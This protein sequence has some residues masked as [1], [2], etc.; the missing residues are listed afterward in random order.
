[1]KH[2]QNLVKVQHRFDPYITSG[3]SEAN[4]YQSIKDINK[5]LKS[6][7]PVFNKSNKEL[8]LN[9]LLNDVYKFILK[10]EGKLPSKCYFYID[11]NVEPPVSINIKN[12][13]WHKSV[14]FYKNMLELRKR[15]INIIGTFPSRVEWAFW[16]PQLVEQETII[17]IYYCC[18]Q[19]TIKIKDIG[20]YQW[21]SDERETLNLEELLRKVNEFKTSVSQ[22]RK[23]ADIRFRSVIKKTRKLLPND[24]KIKTPDGSSDFLYFEKGKTNPKQINRVYFDY[25]WS[26]NDEKTI[27]VK[28]IHKPHINNEL[29]K[30]TF[31]VNDKNIVQD[32]LTFVTEKMKLNKKQ[33][34]D[35]CSF[36]KEVVHNAKNRK[37]ELKCKKGKADKWATAYL[38]WEGRSYDGPV[39]RDINLCLDRII[40]HAT[41]PIQWLSWDVGIIFAAPSPIDV[42]Y[43]VRSGQVNKVDK[44]LDKE[45]RETL[46]KNVGK[47]VTT[48]E[49]AEEDITEM[50]QY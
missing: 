1:M 32:V 38:D 5:L 26:Y 33:F 47:V 35:E 8:D 3:E 7:I 23:N 30:K 45:L 11:P 4:D 49:E 21:Q 14:N 12:R 17:R 34:D 42:N 10:R 37:I 28:L 50:C 40:K 2:P 41:G 18:N 31:N 24:I 15:I 44:E 20:T 48:R 46:N 25:I 13:V 43:M 16:A 19:I 9:I 6:N 27:N 29:S 36:K 22:E 39:N